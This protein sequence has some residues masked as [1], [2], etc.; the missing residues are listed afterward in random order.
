MED[1]SHGVLIGSVV[2][3]T[4][5]LHSDK[6]YME[7]IKRHTSTLVKVLKNL[8]MSGYAPEHDISGITDP[9]LQVS[10][11][12]LLRILGTKDVTSS[13]TMNDTLA[14]VATNTES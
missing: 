2:L 6:S 1:R 8:L 14:Q 7:Q 3:S 10:I 5:I 12:S 13:D 9:F 11:L 4:A